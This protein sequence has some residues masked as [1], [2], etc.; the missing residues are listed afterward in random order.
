MVEAP[1]IDA[2][3][4]T[5]AIVPETVTSGVPVV[6][7]A[8]ILASDTLN[9]VTP[10]VSDVVITQVGIVY[11]EDGVVVGTPTL[12]GVTLDAAT[13]VLSVD[14]GSS[15]FKAEVTYQIC[16]ILNPLN[17]ATAVETVLV[18]PIE[19]EALPES[20]A[21]VNGY[22]GGTLGS[23]IG[24]DVV[25]DGVNPTT[26]PVT[27]DTDPT[28]G[29]T[30]TVQSVTDGTNPSLDV[31]VDPATGAVTV[32]AGT[33]AGT[34]EITYDICL[35]SVPTTCRTLTELVDVTAPEITA[36]DDAVV[37][38]DGYLGADDVL[39]VFGNDTLN[40]TTLSDLSETTVA[41]ITPAVSIGGGNVP[42]LDP[43]D[44]TI[45]VPAGT[46][47]GV[48]QITYELC[49]ILNPLNCDQAV[50][51]VTV[52][53]PAVDAVDDLVTGVDGFAGTAGVLQV[54]D[55]DTVSGVSSTPADLVSG[56][57]TLSVVTPAVSIG[58]GN[59][60]VLD[61][62]TG[63]VD[64]PAGT[65]AGTY[66]ITYELCETLNAT[67]CD[68]AVAT[69]VVALPVIVA[70][71][72]DLSATVVNGFDGGLAGNVYS[73][74]TLNSDPAAVADT[75]I[76]V[77]NDGGVGIT[78]D[79]NGDVV[80]PA[81][82]P[83]DTYTVTY[84]LCDDLNPGNC[85]TATVTVVVGA[86]VIAAVVDDY[87][88]T[89]ADGLNGDVTA[90]VLVNDQY[91]GVDVVVDG[92]GLPVDVVLT[93]GVAPVTGLSM[94]A[95]GTITVAAQTAP[96][97]YSY[98]YEICDALNLSLCSTTTATVVVA[99]SV[100][101]ADDDLSGSPVNGLT[102]GDTPSVL[103]GDLLN[104]NPVA[105]DGSD[106]TI[107]IA[108]DGGLSGVTVADNGVITVPALTPP[109]TYLV[110]YE[111]CSEIDPLVCDTAVATIVVDPV[112]DAVDVDLSASP[113]NGLTG[114]VTPSVLGDD[115]LN[116]NPIATDG[117]ETT[118]SIA[119]EGGLTGVTIADNGVITVPALTPAGTYL[120][121]YEICYALD[122]LVCDTA[123]ATVEVTA[124][125]IE[126]VVDDFSGFPVN[127]FDG[128]TVGSVLDNDLL[129]GTGIAVDGS[130]SALSIVNTGGLTGVT[131][132]DDGTLTVPAGTAA[133]SYEV[134]YEICDALNPTNCSQA[135]AT[136]LVVPPVI[137]AVPDLVSG[138]D[139][140]LGAN[141]VITVLLND[142]LN[143]TLLTDLSIVTLSVVTPATSIGGQPVP[144][145]DPLD[146]T[147]DVPVG[148]PE[149]TYEI[150]Y[151]ICEQFNLSNC[152]QTT[153][154]I[155]VLASPPI[156]EDDYIP[157]L[158]TTLP[159]TV[160]IF[161]D[162][163]FGVDRDLDG[164]LAPDS[165]ILTLTGMPSGAVVSTD[166]K[167]LT[168]PG[169]G[170]WTVDSVSG[171]V[172]FA[173]ASG[174]TA[175]P[176]PASYV[177]FDNDANPSNEATI[178][179]EFDVQLP[180]AA[181]DLV[182]GFAT[183]QAVTVDPFADN[184]YG[185]D[186]DPDGALDP[187]SVTLTGV[188]APSGSTLSADG[189]SLVVPGEG[190]WTVDLISG[191]VTFTPEADFIADPTP[192]SYIASDNDGNLSNEAL[193]TVDYLQIPKMTLLKSVT[194]VIDA[195]DDGTIGG[196][197]DKL[198][199]TFVVENVGEL[200][201]T[202]ITINDPA[203]GDRV[204]NIS[205][206][207]IGES[208][209][210]SALYL[211]TRADQDR[212]YM[213]NSAT[214][215]AAPI[216]Q[217]GDPAIDPETG[218][219]LTLT[220]ISDAGSDM[221]T[222]PIIDPEANETPD[223]EGVTDG[224]ATNDPTVTQ[225]PVVPTGTFISGIAF[226]DN[227]LNGIYDAE[228]D[229]LLPDYIVKLLDANGML[230]E[231]SVT[232]ANGYYEMSNFP[233]GTDYSL[234]FIDPETGEVVSTI[235]G[236]TFVAG[237]S[238]MDVDFIEVPAPTSALVLTK[239]AGVQFVNFG[240]L[241]PYEITVTNDTDLPA[242][243]V[244]VVDTM[245]SGIS[246]VDGSA[247]V[248]GEE[249][250]IEASGRQVVFTGLTVPAGE[251][252]I[253]T[254]KGRVNASATMSDMVN[255]AIATDIDG[256]TISEEVTASVRRAPEAVFDCTDIIGRVFDDR[257][258]NG[259]QDGPQGQDLNARMSSS[260]I[261]DQSYYGTKLETEPVADPS[262]SEPGL[263]GVRLMTVDG[264][265]ITTDEF[266]RYSVP[267][268]AL[269]QR[270]GSNFVIKV[271]TSSLPTG[272]RLTTENPRVQRI[273]SGTVT[274]FNFGAAISN[275]VEIDLTASAFDPA[276]NDPVDA[277]VAGVETIVNQL[278]SEP[279]VLRLSYF[280]K[281]EG[282]PVARARLD[283][284]EDLISDSWRGR[285]RYQLLI[286]RTIKN[287][288]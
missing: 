242:Y 54:L 40:G 104:G 67:N 65:P 165:V 223:G 251:T 271:D 157:G 59:V 124:P 72:D 190:T 233:T 58:G 89:P 144:V 215:V 270:G 263:A 272:Y 138:V 27:L 205:R 48:Y 136:V 63:L 105:T 267:C 222:D 257:N 286:E 182:S 126:A 162:T 150:T 42:V 56:L 151:E 110:T 149:G 176:T 135:I 280:M 170:E 235:E 211:I 119:D 194:E 85:D 125:V 274:K 4:E 191:L 122:A 1:L 16:E 208:A 35:V 258:M 232:D 71:D 201:L 288:Q 101:A 121:E 148:T 94:N 265:I 36:T 285:G 115:L 31:T 111:I 39:T 193:I 204:F 198:R 239:T 22:E 28:T 145:L 57:A 231:E 43:A 140:I 69:V 23:I 284:L 128:G 269:P 3:A 33:P 118:I 244:R 206:L 106:T 180:V 130:Q 133:G 282:E 68:T 81:G 238:M 268:A 53:A 196:I 240:D 8:D 51:R 228:I 12:G 147:V 185:L 44:G 134:L 226:I 127:G 18:P 209:T 278:R 181:D 234:Q 254:L 20:Y 96:G 32:A 225:I 87:S 112:I 262:G 256:M 212:G 66:E 243:N 61:P 52:V 17:C 167:T 155:F 160:D 9:G 197:G 252:L 86:P 183:G 164:T 107:S 216:D 259:Y 229:E 129:N 7:I 253:L 5:V 137:T 50:A 108:D 171:F 83:A 192:V 116:G 11:S 113:V 47:A 255:R 189:K 131:I 199:F 26:T 46:P 62:A 249:A 173:P 55:G 13:G 174:F 93:P 260:G 230:V 80:V 200:D 264:L 275:V 287:V 30:L 79:D 152:S 92:A 279:S 132:A 250:S 90:S 283:A 114:G 175:N 217:N 236:L 102:G 10:T 98:P 117:S 19:L 60:P 29:V 99:P 163:G 78:I 76:T 84:E 276:T 184:G 37:D 221:A 95:D 82:T 188:G 2:V 187:A 70:G 166:G 21:I 218:D 179:L 109:G 261:T 237:T 146:G 143:G 195:V 77:T 123:I 266:G 220:D 103:A 142:S 168:V 273:T 245:P 100:A 49:E 75:T 97:T 247:M 41:V 178:T 177:I 241:V 64:V 45:D 73:T 139:G 246:Y 154:T 15:G 91:N 219:L 153:A 213:E 141:D 14:A 281:G 24:S 74:D 120:V 161:A 159:V 224:D 207:A 214:A 38:I 277:L 156:A 227:N 25:G 88:A 186:A 248:D 158:E 203:F 210:R 172:T 169:E 6:A 34:Y 202:D